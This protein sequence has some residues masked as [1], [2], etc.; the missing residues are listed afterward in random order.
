M[1]STQKVLFK[2]H[3]KSDGSFI[4]EIQLNRPKALNALDMEIVS[5]ITEYLNKWQARPNLSAVFL[6][7]A[8]KSFCVGGDVKSIFFTIQAAKREKK[9]IKKTLQPFFTS[10]YRLDYL[11]HSYSRPV[12]VWG[13]GLVMGGG[14]GLLLSGSH[15]ILSENTSVS[16]PEIAIGFFTDVGSSYFLSRLN[17]GIGW[18]LALTGY[19][20]N[21]METRQ[22]FNG[23][24]SEATTNKKEVFCF[25][26]LDKEKILKLLISSAFKTTQDLNSLL[27][28]M[29]KNSNIL[30]VSVEN[31]LQD[32]KEDIYHLVQSKNIQVIYQNFKSKLWKKDGKGYE[33]QQAILKASP[34]SLGIICELL[35][36]AEN[37]NLKDV[38]QMDLTVAINIAIHSIDFIEGVRARLVDKTGSP[39]WQPSQLEQLKEIDIQQYFQ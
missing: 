31:W 22:L 6:H 3:L 20:C 33:S 18:F 21:Y 10:E 30:S 37:K 28:N 2:E 11:L 5:A 17:D 25:H 13:D 29:E 14:V 8:G 36:R 19:R 39:K 15:M 23:I 9:D 16:M 32:N 26:A 7:G 35:K 34:T 27:R 12:I 1:M 4:G 38:F 24:S